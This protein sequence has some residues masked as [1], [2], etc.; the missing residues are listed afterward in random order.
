MTL[1][2]AFLL[3][4]AL[5]FAVLIWEGIAVILENRQFTKIR[6][7]LD[8]ELDDSKMYVLNVS[9]VHEDG[10]VS[11]H[12]YGWSSKWLF[13]LREAIEKKKQIEHMY[14]EVEILEHES[15][16]KEIKSIIENSKS[17]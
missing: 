13:T 17:F 9:K 11:S 6:S 2:L 10:G 3:I 14:D 4:P 12:W 15:E 7:E 5:I 1:N 8:N 16:Q